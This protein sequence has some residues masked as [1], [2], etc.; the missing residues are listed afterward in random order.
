MLS[1]S[2]VETSLRRDEQAYKKA[3]ILWQRI[4]Q[5]VTDVRE[6]HVAYLLFHCALTPSEIVQ[7]CS[8]EFPDI[9]E[10]H[11]L[12]CALLKKLRFIVYSS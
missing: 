5:L 11:S 2:P 4:E 10:V 7:H 8:Y 6:R 1:T 12:L 3:D 9:Q